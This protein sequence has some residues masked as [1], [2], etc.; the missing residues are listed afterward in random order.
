MR[1]NDLVSPKEAV[2]FFTERLP[3]STGYR[4]SLTTLLGEFLSTLEER[5]GPRDMSYTPL[6]IEYAEEGPQ[7]WYPGNRKQIS[8]M[9]PEAALLDLDFAVFTLAHEAVHVLAPTGGRR[10]PVVEEGLATL[11]Q[12]ET[13]GTYSINRI[14]PRDGP[15]YAAAAVSHKL[16]GIE[17]GIVKRLREKVPCFASWTPE[18]LASNCSMPAEFALLLC[19]SFQD[20]GREYLA[21]ATPDGAADIQI[22]GCSL[23]G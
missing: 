5:Y 8:I 3:S 19:Q 7:I 14:V 22:S 13:A 12:I 20:F 18:F 15:Y 17:P 2:G 10:A 23:A 11:F 4:Y 6:G 21:P 1:T 9:L 16:L